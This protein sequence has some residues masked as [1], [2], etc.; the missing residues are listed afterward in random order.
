M[1]QAPL[2]HESELMNREFNTITEGMNQLNM[3]Y[4]QPAAEE[5][6]STQP[7]AYSSMQDQSENSLSYDQTQWTQQASY[8][9]TEMYHEQ[10]QTSQEESYNNFGNQIYDPLQNQ[11]Q[12]YGS[13]F[14]Q[15]N[16]SGNYWEQQ[17]HTEEV[18]GRTRI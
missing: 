18:S 13:G 11:G 16:S 9:Q 6:T 17:P 3:R 5:P 15:T 1:Q 4:Q 7:V 14:D 12:P 10:Q 8:G 2:P